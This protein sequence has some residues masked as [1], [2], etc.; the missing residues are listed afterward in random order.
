MQEMIM[1][2]RGS[3]ACA[4]KDLLSSL[5]SQNNI[6]HLFYAPINAK[7]EGRYTGWSGAAYTSFPPPPPPL[8]QYIHYPIIRVL[9]GGVLDLNFVREVLP[10]PWDPDPVYDKKFTKIMENWYPVYDF[11]VKFHS[12]FRQSAWFL[13]P[14]YRKSLKIFEIETLFMSGRSK[15][16]TLKGGTSPYN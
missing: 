13:N 8:G 5:P 7:P 4:F 10:V 9:P 14:V 2:Y 6:S 3:R 11:P 12:F 15:N 16:H 1:E